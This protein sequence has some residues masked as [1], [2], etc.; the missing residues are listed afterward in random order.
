MQQFANAQAMIKAARESGWPAEF[1]DYPVLFLDAFVVARAGAIFTN[2]SIH[3]VSFLLK[4]LAD[5][6]LDLFEGKTA[7]VERVDGFGDRKFCG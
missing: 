4:F 2:Q 7:G 6:D 3:S 1:G 5:V